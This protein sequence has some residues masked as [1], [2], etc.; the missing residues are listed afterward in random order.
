M[1]TISSETKK[2]VAGSLLSFYGPF[3]GA[4]TYMTLL[5][6]TISLET[7]YT[8]KPLIVDP[9]RRDHNRSNL[10]TGTTNSAPKC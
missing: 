9:P 7:L 10:S 2:N 1:K 8:V 5:V 3:M 6:H 4:L